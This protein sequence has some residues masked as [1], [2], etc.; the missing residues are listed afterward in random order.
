MSNRTRGTRRGTV[1]TSKGLITRE[2]IGDRELEMRM[3]RAGEHMAAGEFGR[4]VLTCQR[5]LARLPSADA[6]RADT[7]EY[8]G[9]AHAML[10]NFY[11]SYDAYTEALALRPDD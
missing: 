3:G 6:R 5:I 7:L 10:Q 9:V 11:D 8:L 2:P 4:V 1:S